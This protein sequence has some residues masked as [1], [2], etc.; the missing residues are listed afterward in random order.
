M[1]IDCRFM[2][3]LGIIDELQ[4]V[5]LIH[6]FDLIAVQ[7]HSSVHSSVQRSMSFREWRRAWFLTMNSEAFIWSLRSYDPRAP[8]RPPKKRCFGNGFVPLPF[9]PPRINHLDRLAMTIWVLGVPCLRGEAKRPAMRIPS[10]WWW[11][12]ISTQPSVTLHHTYWSFENRPNLGRP[13]L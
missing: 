3:I 9:V 13:L 7:I 8:A 5:L 10:G 4:C 11:T 2:E 1:Q 6:L 12:A